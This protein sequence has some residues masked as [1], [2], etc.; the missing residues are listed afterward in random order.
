[1]K[2]NFSIEKLVFWDWGRILAQITRYE[3]SELYAVNC[4]NFLVIKSR[5]ERSELAK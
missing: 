3:R 4:V 5:P 2:A 1:M